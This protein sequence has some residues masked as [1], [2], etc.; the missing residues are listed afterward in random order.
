MFDL[1]RIS[2]SRKTNNL[3]CVQGIIPALKRKLDLYRPIEKEVYILRTCYVQIKLQSIVHSIIMCFIHVFMSIW[4][5]E[6]MSL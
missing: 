6:F 1:T 4:V 3:L 2:N 5:F